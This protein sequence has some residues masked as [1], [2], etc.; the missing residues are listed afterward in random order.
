M[1]ICEIL[2]FGWYFS[3]FCTSDMSIEVRISRSVS[4]GPFDFEI[5]RVDCSCIF[6]ILYMFKPLKQQQKLQQTTV[7]FFLLLSFNENK[8]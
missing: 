6:F 5:T 7:C 8:A 3:Q 4:E 2:L 1:F